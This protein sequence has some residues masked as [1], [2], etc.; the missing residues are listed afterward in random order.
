MTHQELE[1]ISSDEGIKI[2]KHN[3]SEYKPHSSTGAKSNKNKKNNNQQSP[4][5]NFNDR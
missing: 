1:E 4:E 2:N 3:T 5:S